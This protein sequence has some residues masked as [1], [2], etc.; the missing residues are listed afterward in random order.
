MNPGTTATVGPPAEEFLSQIH[1]GKLFM[2]RGGLDASGGLT[3]YDAQEARANRIMLYAAQRVFIVADHSKFGKA[4]VNKIAPLDPSF[5][6]ITDDK[7]DPRLGAEI[8]QIG[9]DPVLV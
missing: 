3:A 1:V 8:R 5:T 9:V 4:A 2:S 6:V 7:L